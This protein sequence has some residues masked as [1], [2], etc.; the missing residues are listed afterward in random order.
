MRTL[1][2]LF[3]IVLGLNAAEVTLSAL[4]GELK[5]DRMLLVG[6]GLHTDVPY[7]VGE[8]S[9]VQLLLNRTAVITAS[10]NSVFILKTLSDD[11]VTLLLQQGTYK[12]VNLANQYQHLMLLVDT[13]TLSMDMSDTV[14]LIKITTDL[15][16]A[17]CAK[18]SFVAVYGDE[19]FT[20]KDNEVLILKNS[21]LKKEPVDYRGFYSVLVRNKSADM[22]NVHKEINR[23]DPADLE[24]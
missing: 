2:L 3:F 24:N 20:A 12:I 1:M 13:P 14:A 21:V 8:N 19:T 9:K 18:R 6:E 4:V 22:E 15:T 23:E 10:Q 5:G 11:S 17:A 16:K 7:R